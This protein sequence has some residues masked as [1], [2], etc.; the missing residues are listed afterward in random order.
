VLHAVGKDVHIA[1][2]DGGTT[3]TFLVPA[4]TVAAPLRPRPLVPARPVD[5]TSVERA[6][7]DPLVLRVVGD[8]DL[9]G[10]VAVRAALLAALVPGGLVVDLHRA[11][12]VSSAGVA[13]LVELSTQAREQDVALV[14][15]ISPG[16]RV[17]RVLELTGLRSALPVELG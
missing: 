8:L 14:L 12:Y 9:D 11:G 5:T 17:A 1:A 16:S 15:R 10:V 6:G 2:G 4:P 13:L 7:T 3:V